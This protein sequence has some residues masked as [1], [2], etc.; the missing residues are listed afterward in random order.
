[1]AAIRFALM[2]LLASFAAATAPKIITLTSAVRLSN[3]AKRQDCNDCGSY[4]CPAESVCCNGTLTKPRLSIFTTDEV[5]L[6]IR[7]KGVAHLSENSPVGHHK[8]QLTLRFRTTC[9]YNDGGIA[10]G[11]T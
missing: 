5:I 4:C 8:Y 9:V 7:V 6:Q 3:F 1:M 11:C 10:T 2:L